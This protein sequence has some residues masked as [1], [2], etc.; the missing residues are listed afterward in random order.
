MN[1]G[2]SDPFTTKFKL[3]WNKEDVEAARNEGNYVKQQ[4]VVCEYDLLW[5]TEPG[6]MGRGY[7]VGPLYPRILYAFSDV[8]LFVLRNPRYVACE[9][10]SG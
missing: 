4:K 9:S 6:S 7:A 3:K 10:F 2:E 8:I 1:G 5:S